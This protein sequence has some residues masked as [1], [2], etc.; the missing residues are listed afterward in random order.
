MANQCLNFRKRSHRASEAGQAML[1]FVLVLAIFLL[2]AVCL[3]FDFS[4]MW[5]H[6]Q[7]AQSAA[8][9]AC[10]AGAMDLLV[11]AQGGATG[12]QGFTP[13]T[14]FDCS[15]SGNPTASVCQYALKN[16]YDSANSTPGN[17]VS[18]SFPPGVSG[19]S[20]PPASM[21]PTPFIRVDVL[22]HVQTFFLGLLSGSRTK[23]VRAFATCGLELASS[24][25]PI[26]VLDPNNPNVRPASS[27][28]DVQGNPAI[29]IVGGP[30][31]SIQVDSSDPAA[32]NI[33]GSGTID[34]SKA[35]PNGTGAD[36]GIY[37]G[38]ATAPSGFNGGT[39]GHWISPAAPINDP[40]AQLAA[41]TDPGPALAW[42]TFTPTA[43]GVVTNQILCPDVKCSQFHPGKYGTGLCIGKSA[44]CICVGSSNTCSA[45]FDPGVYYI[46]GN[47][48]VDANSCLRPSGAADLA[49][50]EAFGGIVFYFTG[51]GSVSVDA[52]SGSKCTTPFVTAGY[53]GT[54]TLQYGVKCTATSQIQPPNLLPAT[55]TG[56]VL[57]APC[58]G[59]Y[60][61]PLGAAD[62]MGVQRGILLFQDRSTLSAN[63]SWGG[64]GS[65]LL[66]GTMYFHSCN[67]SGTG[68]P[69]GA[70][71]TYLNDIFTLQGGSGSTTYVLGDIIAD[72]IALGGN[73]AITM[74][75]NPTRAFTILKAS[76]LQ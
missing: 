19:I 17:L 57:L 60:G 53:A 20:T 74:D 9:A 75:L 24:P 52:N 70:A 8:D 46:N 50:G 61:D 11:D 4:N 42:S 10:T 41:P 66:A 1:F 72:N 69:C 34:L 55:L 56:N 23:D 26:L 65:F 5:F 47:F 27:A 29:T 40:F 30:T 54:S 64:S 22:E 68:A 15:S 32:T 49:T 38:P 51:G 36:I 7:A 48:K 31:K 58:T 43:A 63:Q 16:G 62:P 2:G 39:T 45:I 35:G 6:R 33:G 59:T 18:V 13:G 12:H 71:G 37:G 28:L 73:S 44:G 14:N 67:S 21:A 76:L 3:A 25:I